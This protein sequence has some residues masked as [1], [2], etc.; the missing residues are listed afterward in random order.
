MPTNDYR[1]NVTGDLF[2]VKHR[3]KESLSTWG[4]LCEHTG[5]DPGDIALDSPVAR[6]ATGGQVVKS[7]SHGEP[8]AL[9][10]GPAPVAAAC[11][12]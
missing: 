7:S 11:A 12:A 5:M 8:A 2:E 1:C 4:E 3:M 9:H 10:A 6:L